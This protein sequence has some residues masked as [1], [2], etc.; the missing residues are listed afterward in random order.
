M[1][2]N[3]AAPSD[4][5][6]DIFTTFEQYAATMALSSPSVYPLRCILTRDMAFEFIKLHIVCIQE[7]DA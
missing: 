6:G 1:I 2:P 4:I 3:A 5:N 7:A